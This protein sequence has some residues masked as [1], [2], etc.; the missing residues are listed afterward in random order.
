MNKF[1]LFFII[2]FSFNTFAANPAQDANETL[3]SSKSIPLENLDAA[4]AFKHGKALSI[5]RRP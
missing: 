5:A 2:S 3:N 1:T 4:D